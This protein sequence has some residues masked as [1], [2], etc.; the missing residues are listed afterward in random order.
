MTLV[1]YQMNHQKPYRIGRLILLT[2]SLLYLS[3]CAQTKVVDSWKTDKP[4]TNKPDKVAVIAVL[5][6]ALMR[7]AVE[8]DVAR[9]LADKG[10]PAVASSRLPGFSGQGAVV[11]W[12]TLLKPEYWPSPAR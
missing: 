9:I 1:E 5:P 12:T 4:V 3:A 2:L 7:E 10:S 6:E 8:V 11:S